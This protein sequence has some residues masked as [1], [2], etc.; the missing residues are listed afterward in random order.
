MEAQFQGNEAG[1][2]GT[3]AQF[4]GTEAGFHGTEARLHGKEVGFHGRE[5]MSTSPAPQ[6]VR[7]ARLRAAGEVT[8]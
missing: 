2:H 1:F 8:P 6:R 4:Q 5:S 7:R 3:E